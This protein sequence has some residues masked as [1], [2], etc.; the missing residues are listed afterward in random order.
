VT[1]QIVALGGGGFSMEP[2]NPLLDRYI[3]SQTA[4]PTPR[5]L[6]VATAAGDSD[7]YIA[8]FYAA[9]QR[10]PCE[11]T[12]LSLFKPDTWTRTPEE[13]LETADVLYFSG[14]STKNALALWR[15]WDLI[16]PLRAAYERGAVLAGVSAGAIVWFENFSTDSA[17]RDLAVLDG[18]GWL[19]GSMTPHLDSE[20]ERRPSL[21]RFLEAGRI[22]P[23]FAADDGA[24]LHFKGE[25]L[26]GNVW[27]RRRQGGVNGVGHFSHARCQPKCKL[28]LG[29]MMKL[30]NA[31]VYLVIAQVRFNTILNLEAF[32]PAIQE[33][34][35]LKG[36]PDFQ[37]Q[38]TQQLV[39]PF[40]NAEGTP[41]SVSAQ[42]RFVFGDMDG[43]QNFSLDNNAISFQTTQYET[44]EEF[45]A[46]F[47]EGVQIVHEA[48]KLD[49][50]ER[51]GVRYLDAIFPKESESFSDYL[52]PEVIGLRQKISGE[53]SHSFSETVSKD[54][55]MQLIARSYI[56]N[57]TLGIPNEL[58][59]RVPKIQQKFLALN[60]W[61]AILD[62][63]A[64]LETRQAFDLEQIKAILTELK[65]KIATS[66]KSVT[67]EHAMKAWDTL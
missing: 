24:A 37:R 19:P 35:R 63:D 48:I 36:F 67:T 43:Q 50:F 26:H 13:Q 64:S 41:P 32:V 17:G 49:Y 4:N 23:G 53:V 10:L 38:M 61:H 11:A 65:E 15:E 31:P 54:N 62:N 30:K 55:Q 59:G 14:G 29:E 5:V 40:G 44:F 47:L 33:K 2:E 22:K 66:F 21:R 39:M 20:P 1:R 42:V 8:R 16:Q 52:I 3:L 6:F 46:L 60:G 28:V 27:S 51:I 34:M 18:L 58:V 56:Q 9:F 7:G 12:H 45:S 57:A 25:T